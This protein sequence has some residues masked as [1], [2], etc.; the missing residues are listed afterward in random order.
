[1]HRK[2]ARER[3]LL[4]LDLPERRSLERPGDGLAIRLAP[5]AARGLV[6]EHGVEVIH[7]DEP[8]VLGFSV[9]RRSEYAA[10]AAHGAE[11]HHDRLAV[12]GVTHLVV[13]SDELHR[14]RARLP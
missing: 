10:G 5:P 14:V 7:P 12:D 8:E 1:M 2:P 11:G 9:D 4:A 3:D 13:V 6:L